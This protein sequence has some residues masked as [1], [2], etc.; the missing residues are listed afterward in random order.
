MLDIELKGLFRSLEP[1]GTDRSRIT[2]SKCEYRDK[3]C[4]LILLARY[5]I[6]EKDG[7]KYISIGAIKVGGHYLRR[8]L[9]KNFLIGVYNNNI[10]YGLILDDVVSSKLYNLLTTTF[11]ITLVHN[12]KPKGL[13][14]SW[15]NYDKYY[16]QFIVESLK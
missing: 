14:E 3:E 11:K 1:V 7:R 15:D 6:V 4:N 12:G 8:G 5:I 9:C 2:A 10:G 13:N 16:G